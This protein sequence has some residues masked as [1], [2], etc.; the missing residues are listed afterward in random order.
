[1]CLISHIYLLWLNQSNDM[2]KDVKSV[3][4]A[5]IDIFVKSGE[6]DLFHYT[7]ASRMSIVNSGESG[8]ESV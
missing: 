8:V 4:S 7:V 6:S 2:W 1:M 3:E 5:T